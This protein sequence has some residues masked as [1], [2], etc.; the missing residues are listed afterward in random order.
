MKKYKIEALINGRSHA[1]NIVGA[2]DI[3]EAVKTAEAY[4]KAVT[5]GAE[6]RSVIEVYN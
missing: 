1:L 5:R 2:R 6:I 3:S 4:L